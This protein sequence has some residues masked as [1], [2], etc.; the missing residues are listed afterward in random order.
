[1]VAEYYLD[2]REPH[3]HAT[4]LHSVRNAVLRHSGK[5]VERTE[6]NGTAF[7]AAYFMFPQP[8]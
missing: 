1:L 7:C 4:S 8:E 2:I 5:M 3:Q 6:W